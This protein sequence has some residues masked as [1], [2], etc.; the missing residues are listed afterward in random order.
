MPQP[1]HDA[2]LP[3]SSQVFTGSWEHDIVAHLPADYAQQA[4]EKKAFQRARQIQEDTLFLAGWVLL[5]STLD[6]KVWTPQLALRLYRARWQV[7]LLFKRMK[8]ILRLNQIRSAHPQ[9]IQ[10]TLFALFLAWA[11]QEQEG[12]WLREQLES[13]PQV[14]ASSSEEC[15]AIEEREESAA[16]DSEYDGEAGPVSS[17]LLATMVLQTLRHAVLGQWSVARLRE[18]LP[19][20]RRLL[21]GS[22][23]R[24][25]H[26]ERQIRTRLFALFS[27]G[28]AYRSLKSGHDNKI[29]ISSRHERSLEH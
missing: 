6:P 26:Q 17:W 5:V 16:P 11:L 2:H 24:R 28:S 23:R 7:E 3:E 27:S 18:I 1:L 22:H 20:L 9:T 14:M 15:P 10:A 8:Q 21:C 29:L 19:R 13:L 25:V 4:V 12:Q